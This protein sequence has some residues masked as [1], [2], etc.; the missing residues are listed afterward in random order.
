MLTPKL[1]VVYVNFRKKYL[2]K[3]R[4]K[5]KNMRF[6][7]S[8]FK[9][10]TAV[11]NKGKRIPL[12]FSLVEHICNLSDETKNIWK[13]K[14]VHFWHRYIRLVFRT[15]T[16]D[17]WCNK[18]WLNKTVKQHEAKPNI[19]SHARI[20]Q[21]TR[22]MRSNTVASCPGI[23]SRSNSW[24]A[25]T[26]YFSAEKDVRLSLFV[27]CDNTSLTIM[28]PQSPQ[29]LPHHLQPRRSLSSLFI[30]PTVQFQN[31]RYWLRRVWKPK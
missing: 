12:I 22:K 29:P 26:S 8:I 17:Q 28:V 21:Q 10:C 2:N 16:A 14:R 13:M 3:I 5:S 18:D 25:V 24:L 27:A 9:Q 19:Y 15:W 4:W 6:F 11:W 1:P 7:K 23:S 31:P 20:Y 30:T